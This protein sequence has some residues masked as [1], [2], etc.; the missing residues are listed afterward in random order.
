MDMSVSFSVEYGVSR[1]LKYKT[2]SCIG[3]LH[4]GS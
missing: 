1:A 2:S 3:S 4:R